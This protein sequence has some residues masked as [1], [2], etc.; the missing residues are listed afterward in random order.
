[1]DTQLAGRA[2]DD[3]RRAEWNTAGKSKSGHGRWV[4]GLR[5]SLLKAPEKQTV[6]QLAALHEASTA[7]RRLYRA[8]LLKEEL[9][10]EVVPQFVDLET[11]VPP[12]RPFSLRACV[13][14]RSRSKEEPP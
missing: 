5:W 11:A 6:G 12:P 8:F 4:K 7:N 3:V 9:R 13:V 2:V 14:I 1:L 10:L